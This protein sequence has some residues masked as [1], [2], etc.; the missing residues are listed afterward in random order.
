M[1]RRGAGGTIVRFYVMVIPDSP[2]LRENLHKWAEIVASS[3]DF[4]R[5]HA[6]SPRGVGNH[7]LW[8]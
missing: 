8:R 1:I 5:N 2:S 4:V 3:A 7:A 6:L